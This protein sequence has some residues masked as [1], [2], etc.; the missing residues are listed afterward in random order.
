MRTSTSQKDL[1]LA[2]TPLRDSSLPAIAAH[3]RTSVADWGTQQGALS[4]QK[5]GKRMRKEDSGH[6][7]ASSVATVRSSP[8]RSKVH[9]NNRQRGKNIFKCLPTPSL[10]K[11]NPGSSSAR[12]QLRRWAI[13]LPLMWNKHIPLSLSNPFNTE[14]LKGT[15]C[16]LSYSQGL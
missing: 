7:F 2:Q 6:D 16:P 12:L 3:S 15:Q 5:Q 13:F 11:K 4:S 10:K 8:S 1:H 9:S 14:S